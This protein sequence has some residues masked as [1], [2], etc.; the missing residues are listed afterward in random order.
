MFKNTIIY[1]FLIICLVSCGR[2][3]DP[4]YKTELLKKNIINNILYKKINEK[5]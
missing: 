5:F 2:K 3:S 4:V 1:I